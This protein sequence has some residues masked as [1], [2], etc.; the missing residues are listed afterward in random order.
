MRPGCDHCQR[1]LETGEQMT[2]LG[3]K[4]LTTERMVYA[5]VCDECRGQAVA[6][7][8]ANLDRFS[9]IVI[10]RP[11]YAYEPRPFTDELGRL[12]NPLA[13]DA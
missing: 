6:L 11:T 10:R 8:V 3:I 2:D 13:Q 5:S 7:I 12:L 4:D 9:E 1:L